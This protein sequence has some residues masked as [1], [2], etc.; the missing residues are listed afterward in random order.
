MS[1]TTAYPS[2]RESNTVAE[3]DRWARVHRDGFDGERPRSPP[4]GD[5]VGYVGDPAKHVSTVSVVLLVA[6]SHRT[7]Q[8]PRGR[9]ESGVLV[10]SAE[11]RSRRPAREDV[12]RPA[13]RVD[14]GAVSMRA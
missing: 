2:V 4:P 13:E 6:R 10:A 8:G 14:L 12:E 7:D 11:R 1:G 5:P 9:G 3:D